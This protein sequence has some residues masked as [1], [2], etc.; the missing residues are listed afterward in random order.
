VALLDDQDPVPELFLEHDQVP[1]HG[2]RLGLADIHAG[3]GDQPQL[4]TVAGPVEAEELAEAYLLKP[5]VLVVH[6]Q[7]KDG[8][9]IEAFHQLPGEEGFPGPGLPRQDGGNRVAHNRGGCGLGV[10]LPLGGVCE[11]DDEG[12]VALKAKARL[13]LPHPL[14]GIEADAVTG[15]LPLQG[16]HAVP[17]MKNM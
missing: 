6:V 9:I 12:L 4:A 16:L 11:V 5:G 8:T 15:I 7:N 17:L 2:V 3:R 14:N 1:E 10:L 13:E